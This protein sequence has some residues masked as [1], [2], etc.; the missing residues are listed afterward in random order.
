MVD[1]VWVFVTMIAVLTV[2]G[3][4][5]WP[6]PIG[7]ILSAIAGALIAGFGI[8]FRHLVEG[9]PHR[10]SRAGGTSRRGPSGRGS[11]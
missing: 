9:G 4:L 10:Q 2:T 3:L 11:S 6:L 5:R 1:I 7:L 8:P